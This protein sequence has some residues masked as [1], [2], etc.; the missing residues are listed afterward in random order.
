MSEQ[1]VQLNEAVLKVELRE[2]VRQSV[3]ETINKLLEAEAA[4]LTQSARYE[5]TMLDRLFW[6][7]F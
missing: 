7:T 5:R 3:E 2:L 1:V 4:Q 6:T